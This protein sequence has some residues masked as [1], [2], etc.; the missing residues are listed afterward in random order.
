MNNIVSYIISFY[1]Y[2]IRKLSIGRII[3]GIIISVDIIFRYKNLE[4]H[5]TDGGVLPVSVIKGYYPFYQYYFSIHNLLGNS[6]VKLLFFI[7]IVLAIAL[8]LGYYTRLATFF[9]FIF[10]LSLHHRNPLILQGG[11]D[12]LR[13]TLFYMMFIPWG[14][15]YSIDNL[16]NE[17]NKKHHQ[18]VTVNFSWIYL[19]FLIN[20]AF[21]YFFSALLKTEPE[22]RY[23]G[24]AIYYA[25]SLDTLRTPVG[26]ILYSHYNLIKIATFI[27][28]YVFEIFAPLLLIF[29]FNTT[30]RKVALFLIMI[31][32]IFILITLKVGIFP[33]VG[34]TTAIMLL[35]PRQNLLSIKYQHKNYEVILAGVLFM[36][37]LRYNC[38]TLNNNFF[39]ITLYE[40]RLMNCLGLAQR[41][42]MFSPGVKRY[43]GWLV[44]RGIKSDNK[45]WDLIHNTPTLHYEKTPLN[46]PFL[47]GD[48]WRKFI[49][50][51]EQRHYNFIK[52][53]FCYYLIKQWNIYHPKNP[54]E[55]LNIL[56]VK[57]ETL[58]SYQYKI[59]V[60]NLSLCS[61]SD[62]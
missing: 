44:L 30:Y 55:A 22:W 45:D 34:I 6:C 9:N 33:F 13:I 12:L 60:E 42:N 1:P 31:L 48:R 53:Y 40:D 26:N 23:N 61:L 8:I 10:L 62:K 19:V 39:S 58:P 20:V 49:E 59:E 4:A 43:E 56:F 7:H 18:E 17:R 14:H 47:K 27:V 54:I 35:P 51:Y 28:Y 46:F 57:K 32:H 29:S 21:V 50:N 52:P 36:L 25:L 11:D 16:I 37:V 3:I 24:D 15:Y 41:W 38:A 2:D 5:Y